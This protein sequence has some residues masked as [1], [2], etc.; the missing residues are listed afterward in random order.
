MINLNAIDTE[1]GDIAQAIGMDPSEYVTLYKELEKQIDSETEKLPFTEDEIKKVSKESL[2]FENESASQ[3]TINLWRNAGREEVSIKEF[4]LTII[5]LKRLDKLYKEIHLYLRRKISSLQLINQPNFDLDGIRELIKERGYQ[6]LITSNFCYDWLKTNK[7]C[8]DCSSEIACE[9]LNL[10]VRAFSACER[11]DPKSWQDF[12]ETQ[13][14]LNAK[15]D[16]I[17]NAKTLEELENIFV[18]L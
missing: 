3:I 15:V 10:T 8:K 17:L 18:P 4:L 11:Y 7:N 12:L 14:W 2:E 1:A 5:E 16:E 9:K 6:I 13:E